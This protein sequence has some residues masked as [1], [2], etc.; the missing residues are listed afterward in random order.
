MPT[1][2][3]TQGRTTELDQAR[4]E[5]LR[6]ILKSEAKRKS[7]RPRHALD[8]PDGLKAGLDLASPAVAGS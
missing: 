2:S 8:C 1:T 3:E 4:Q 7:R 5:L 6:F